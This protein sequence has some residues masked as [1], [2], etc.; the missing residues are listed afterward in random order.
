M[1]A[2][3]ANAMDRA[4]AMQVLNQKRPTVQ[5]VRHLRNALQ[6]IARMESVATVGV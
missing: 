6:A 2:I 4:P 3:L 1:N 5:R